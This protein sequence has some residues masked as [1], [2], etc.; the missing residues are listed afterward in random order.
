MDRFE[1]VDYGV[2][3]TFGFGY[4]FEFVGL[5]HSLDRLALT[6]GLEY[7]RHLVAFGFGYL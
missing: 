2:G 6:L 7:R 1:Y 5:G 4:Q 3:L